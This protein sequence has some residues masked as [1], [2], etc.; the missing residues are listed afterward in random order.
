[1]ALVR[2]LSPESQS[3]IVAVVAMLEGHDIPCLVHNAGFGGLFPGPQINAYNTRA[4]M[5]PEEKAAEALE[6]IKEY[7]SQPSERAESAKAKTWGK[8]RNIF[9]FFL[10]GWFIP[11][12]RH[13]HEQRSGGTPNSALR[14]SASSPPR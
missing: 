3:E 13:R 7:Q 6:L 14:S 2:V 5:V 1:M 11:G 10:F 4:I 8:V 9:E 12:S